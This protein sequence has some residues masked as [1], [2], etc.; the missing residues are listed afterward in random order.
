MSVRLLVDHYWDEP[1]YVLVDAPEGI[2]GRQIEEAYDA[3][4]DDLKTL[5]GKLGCRHIPCEV[6][7]LYTD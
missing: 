1:T 7:D 3:D 6:I 5:L 2:T 4:T